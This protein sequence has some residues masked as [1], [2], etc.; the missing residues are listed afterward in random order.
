[1]RG[2][3]VIFEAGLRP[4]GA[5]RHRFAVTLTAGSEKVLSLPVPKCTPKNYMAS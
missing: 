5:F 1:M 4:F 2:E 3:P